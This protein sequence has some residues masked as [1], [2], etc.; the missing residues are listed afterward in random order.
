[1]GC[2]HAQ[3]NLSHAKLGSACNGTLILHAIDVAVHIKSRTA[4]RVMKCHV[5]HA[6]HC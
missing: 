3:W 2:D 4:M 1:M 6:V 5:S